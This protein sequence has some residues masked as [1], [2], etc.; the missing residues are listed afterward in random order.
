M[1]NNTLGIYIHVPFCTVKCPY[2]NFYSVKHQSDLE[3]RYISALVADITQHGKNNNSCT[4]DSIY[5]GGGTPSLLSRR[6]LERIFDALHRSFNIST[7]EVT[8]ESNPTTLTAGTL[9]A[10]RS[11]GVNR[12]SVGVQSLSAGDL[13]FLGRKHSPE[14]A[15]KAI[16]TAREHGFQNISA[17]I[18][19]ALPNHTQQN[20]TDTVGELG[21]LGITHL[22]AYMLKV[23]QNTPFYLDGIQVDDEH[24]ADCYLTVCKA[25]EKLGFKQYEISGFA[26][27]GYRCV[28][29]LKYWQLENYLG[30]GPAAH[31][32]VNGERFSYSDDITAYITTS[33]D[34]RKTVSHGRGGDMFERLMLALRLTDGIDPTQYETHFPDI[35]SRVSKLMAQGLMKRVE[36]NYSLTYEGF[37]LSNSVIGYLSDLDE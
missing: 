32:C 24:A 4:V 15:K 26:K 25:A 23:E 30:L 36:D 27:D 28:H 9:S 31:S 16:L 12:L 1:N 33:T 18:I 17:D 19:T 35:S 21:E 8:A 5:L 2:C 34:G 11:V 3:E 37:L 13:A 22:S 20:L 29:N 6:S 10:L 14:Q 7:P